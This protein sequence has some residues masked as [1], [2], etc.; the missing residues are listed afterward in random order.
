MRG[1]GR[2][3][4]FGAEEEIER[5]MENNVVEKTHRMQGQGRLS[6]IVALI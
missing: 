3:A 4:K 5:L 6:A 1:K 2:Q